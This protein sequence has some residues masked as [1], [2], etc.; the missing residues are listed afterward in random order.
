MPFL[1]LLLTLSS[2]TFA[3]DVATL[4]DVQNSHD[5]YVVL[6]D[7]N[8]ESSLEKQFLA[9]NCK[10]QQKS[11]TG[12]LREYHFPRPCRAQIIQFFLNAGYKADQLTKTF[13]KN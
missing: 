2:L 10:P 11:T 13:T 8:L 5:F 12:S 4:E 1:L 6:T 9:Q 3:A 7:S